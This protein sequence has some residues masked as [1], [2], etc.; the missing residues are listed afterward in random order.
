M[1]K[2]ENQASDSRGAG[3]GGR[4]PKSF[5]VDFKGR[6]EFQQAEFQ[7]WHRRQRNSRHKCSEMEKQGCISARA[8]ILVYLVLRLCEGR[9]KRQKWKEG[10]VD[11]GCSRKGLILRLAS[12]HLMLWAAGSWRR[13]GHQE[14]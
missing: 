9:D 13:S 14:N 6:V 7:Q 12:F 2:R 5:E 4:F 10:I 3:R 1:F 11:C 8:S